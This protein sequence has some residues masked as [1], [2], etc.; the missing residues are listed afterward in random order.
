MDLMQFDAQ[1]LYFHSPEAGNVEELLKRAAAD[2]ERGGGEEWLLEARDRSPDSLIV[3][4]ALYR[5]YYYRHRLT[6]AL[7]IARHTLSITSRQLDIS[8]DFR[9]LDIAHVGHAARKSMTLLRFHLLV[10]K[11]TG[12]LLVRLEHIEEGKQMLRKV[13]EIDTCNRLGA[14]DL[15]E[16]I[17]SRWRIVK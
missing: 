14:G 17:E 15:L 9:N 1:E 16:V 5:F 13:L 4:V 10:L 3:M 11:V 2:Y 12:F 6:E 7:A 8:P